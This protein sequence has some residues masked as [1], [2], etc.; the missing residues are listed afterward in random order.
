MITTCKA[1][2]NSFDKIPLK[3]WPESFMK[4]FDWDCEFSDR[5]DTCDEN[6]W[7]SAKIKGID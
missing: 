1:I 2:C 5:A 7:A 6:C 4:P 3:K